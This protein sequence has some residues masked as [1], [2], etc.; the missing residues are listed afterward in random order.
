[1]I[2]GSAVLIQYQRATDRRTD[3]RPAYIYYRTC[4][5]IADARKNRIKSGSYEI[6]RIIKLKVGRN[7]ELERQHVT[8]L[9]EQKTTTQS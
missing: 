4:F 7:G 6:K 2:I 1:M 8:V 9:V 5:S 3:G